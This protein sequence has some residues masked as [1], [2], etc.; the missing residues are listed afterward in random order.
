MALPVLQ[1]TKLGHAHDSTIWSGVVQMFADGHYLIAT[2][3]FLCS[4]V[5]PLGKILGIFTLCAPALRGRL[6]PRHQA[7]TY[8]TIDFLGRWGMIDVLLVAIL[9]AAV[10]LGDW[11]NVAAGPGIIAFAAV[12]V[13]SLLSSITFDP[14]AIWD[15]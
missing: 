7:L 6:S 3:V 1:I 10:K 8:Q 5:I 9:V 14:R 2:I 4:I 15:S 11:V 13:L 12:V